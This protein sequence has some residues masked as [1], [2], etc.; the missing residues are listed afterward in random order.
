MATT[1]DEGSDVIVTAAF[2]DAAG[3]PVVPATAEYRLTT[4][5]GTELLDWTAVSPLGATVEILIPATYHSVAT[6]GLEARH[7]ALRFTY[8]SPAKTGA[9]GLEYHVRA[10]TAYA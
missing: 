5:K 6:G 8:G 10:L 7:L 3:A 1:Y 4:S 9:A 2:R